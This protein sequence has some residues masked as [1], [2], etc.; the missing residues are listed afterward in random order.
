MVNLA[1]STATLSNS[2]SLSKYMNKVVR[3]DN[4]FIALPYNEPNC[5]TI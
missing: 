4:S 2:Y 1:F 3:Q 5:Q